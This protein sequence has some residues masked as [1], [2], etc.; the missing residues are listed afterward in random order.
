MR[1]AMTA[2]STLK[3][4]ITEIGKRLSDRGLVAGT[5][6][7]ISVRIDNDRILVTPSGVAKGRLAVESVVMVDLTGKTHLLTTICLFSF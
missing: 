6:G 7:N 1:V 4:E 5:D 3:Q 2:L